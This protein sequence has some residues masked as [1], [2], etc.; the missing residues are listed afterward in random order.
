[1]ENNQNHTALISPKIIKAIALSYK[2]PYRVLMEYIDNSID[3]ADGNYLDKSENKYRKDISLTVIQTGKAEK[4][5]LTIKDNSGSLDRSLERSFLKNFSIGDSGKA[6]DSSQ[7]GKF[8]FGMMSFL[9]ICEKLTVSSKISGMNFVLKVTFHSKDFNNSFK[10]SLPYTL[11][12]NEYSSDANDYFTSVTL[13]EFKE[14]KFKEFDFNILKSEIELHFDHVLSRKNL[15]VKL[16]NNKGREFICKPFDY[17]LLEGSVFERTMSELQIMHYKKGKREKSVPLPSAVLKIFLKVTKNKA[18]DRPPYFMIN[19]RR[20]DK[21][22][23]FEELR[24]NNKGTI[25]SHPNL[26]GYIDVTGI[27]E[28][29]ITRDSFEDSENVK[30]LF[31]TLLKLEDEIKAFLD[32]E[33]H[34]SESKSFNQLDTK[35]TDAFKKFIQRNKKKHINGKQINTGETFLK[36]S[37]LLFDLQTDN[38]F[39]TGKQKKKIDT[40]TDGVSKK[41]NIC[42]LNTK[43]KDIQIDVPKMERESGSKNDERGSDAITIRIDEQ[44]EPNCDETGTQLRSIFTGEEILIYKKNPMFMKRLNN[45]HSDNLITNK[46]ISYLANEAIAHYCTIELNVQNE[47]ETSSSKLFSDFI[48]KVYEFEIY[49]KELEGKSLNNLV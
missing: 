26:T 44:S 47:F 22:T 40:P 27:V 10:G 9:A 45:S 46:L 33:L 14:T 23:K 18:I 20:I 30:P 28:P 8:G 1:M 2:N 42:R 5:T 39:S 6:S 29:A 7:N 32:A 13:S 12:D 36:D 37:F 16:I 48:S 21:V 3:E 38:R 35:L 49:L 17:E 19:G 31:Y 34:S 11:E 4:N 15:T 25:W 41:E 43:L 24:T